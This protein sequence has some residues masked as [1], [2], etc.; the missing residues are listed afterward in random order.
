MLVFHEKKNVNIY[1]L[2]KKLGKSKNYSTPSSSLWRLYCKQ[3][4]ATV[5]WWKEISL[6]DTD[7]NKSLGWTD[8]VTKAC[9]KVLA[10]IRSI[11]HFA[12]YLHFNIEVIVICEKTVHFSWQISTSSKLLNSFHFQTKTTSS[13]YSFSRKSL[14]FKVDWDSSVSHALYFSNKAHNYLVERYFLFLK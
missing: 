7:E 9:S 1:K 3:S 12:L 5:R 6:S 2:S 4:L 13:C 14:H 10:D 8:Y 11:Q